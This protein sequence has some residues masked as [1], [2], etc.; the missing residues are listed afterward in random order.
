VQNGYQKSNDIFGRTTA[1]VS[2]ACCS[3]RRDP[4]ADSAGS[5]RSESLI[6]AKPI[7]AYWVKFVIDDVW[8]ATSTPTPRSRSCWSIRTAA[9]IRQ[10][11]ARIRLAACLRICQQLLSARAQ[12]QKLPA[13]FV[14]LRDIDPTII[15]DMRYAGSN[16][17]VGRP[18]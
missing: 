14:Y 6:A 1:C 3:R 8:A 11:G 17:F 4:H 2:F 18:L 15:Q 16:N 7:K 10:R 5:K 13:G 12:A 9:V